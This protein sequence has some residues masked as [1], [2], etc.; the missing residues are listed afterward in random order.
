MLNINELSKEF[1]AK[2]IYFEYNKLS[3]IFKF[4]MYSKSDSYD[5]QSEKGVSSIINLIA[6][7]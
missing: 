7:R 1:L 5:C 4:N 6:I 3:Y 2:P